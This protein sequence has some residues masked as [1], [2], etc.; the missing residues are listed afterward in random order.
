MSL[1]D[2]LSTVRNDQSLS[3]T[4]MKTL[5]G[6]DAWKFLP[7]MAT[8]SLSNSS[9]VWWLYMFQPMHVMRVPCLCVHV[10][11]FVCAKNTKHLLCLSH[12]ETWSWIHPEGSELLI[13][14]K[15]RTN[16]EISQPLSLRYPFE[17]KFTTSEDPVR[18][19]SPELWLVFDYL[20]QGR[21]DEVQSDSADEQN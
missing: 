10:R 12:S 18:N 21:S 11:V 15:N 3:Q 7:R 2:D 6:W 17:E 13:T 1:Y 19:G 5:K 20:Q 4:I 14:V 9:S 8:S 16:G